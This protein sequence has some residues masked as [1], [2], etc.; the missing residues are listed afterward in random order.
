[1]CKRPEFS[2]DMSTSNTSLNN[3][4]IDFDYVVNCLHIV[5]GTIYNCL[6][7][8]KTFDQTKKQFRE[9]DGINTFRRFLNE[10]Y[11]DQPGV[12]AKTMII[13]AYTINEDE[14]KII[15]A[16]ENI[17][18]LIVNKLLRSSI[19]SP[20]HYSTLY[21]F[22]AEETIAALNA[23]A[24]ND[25]N[26]RIIGNLGA[27]GYYMEVIQAPLNTDELATAVKGVWILS[28]LPDNHSKIRDIP[29]VLP[30]NLLQAYD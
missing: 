17:L 15:L 18:Q 9:E 5:T 2:L 19:R 20:K 11:K 13:L 30:S 12:Q 14:Q 10:N 3:E 25:S 22:S 28:F 29:G 6:K 27:L 24:L 26:K 4:G 16:T 8:D 1:M 7:K 21:R 23:L